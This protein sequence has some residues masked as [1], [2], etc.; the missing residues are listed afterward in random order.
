MVSSNEADL[1]YGKVS[2]CHVTFCKTVGKLGPRVYEAAH[3]PKDTSSFQGLPKLVT[4][5]YQL[6][7]SA[8]YLIYPADIRDSAKSGFGHHDNRHLNYLAESISMNVGGSYRDVKASSLPMPDRSVGGSIVLGAR[9]SRVRGE[10]SQE[11][12][13]PLLESNG[14]SDECFGRSD[15]PDTP[16]GLR[17]RIGLCLACGKAVKSNEGD[18]PKGNLGDGKLISGE[19]DAVKVASPV[20][21]GE[22]GNMPVTSGEHRSAGWMQARGEIAGP[23]RYW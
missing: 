13:A 5:S 12:N 17:W 2:P 14:K 20:R 11:I 9:K 16:N 15:L 1:T 21:R 19:P 7:V 22:R 10:G 3:E 8:G 23:E 18:K 6:K 4:L